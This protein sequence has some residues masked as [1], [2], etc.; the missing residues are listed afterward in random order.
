M[1]GC[2]FFVSRKRCH[3]RHVFTT[4]TATCACPAHSRTTRTCANPREQHQGR[5]RSS[6]SASALPSASAHPAIGGGKGSSKMFYC[7]PRRLRSLGEATA[8]RRE[9]R[10]PAETEAQRRRTRS[11][12]TSLSWS[13]WPRR[14]LPVLPIRAGTAPHAPP[15]RSGQDSIDFTSLI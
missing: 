2:C 4:P 3:S 9:R 6:V 5:T 10:M 1:D 11:Q 14:L 13:F 7:T 15:A 8:V 12:S